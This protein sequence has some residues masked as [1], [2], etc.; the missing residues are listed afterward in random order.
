MRSNS[1]NFAHV[2]ELPAP[3]SMRALHLMPLTFTSGYRE[4]TLSSL[5]SCQ[6]DSSTGCLSTVSTTG[7][8]ERQV[9]D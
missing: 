6:S 8:V 4:K 9:G 1:V 2:Y 3:E 5:I 7:I